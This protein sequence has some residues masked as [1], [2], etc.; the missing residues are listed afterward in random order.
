VDGVTDELIGQLGQISGLRRVISR[1]TAMK[2][3]ET[4][5]TLSEIARELNVDALV[6][7]AVFQVGENVS[8]KLQ[9]FGALPEERSLWTERYERP[10]TDVLVMYGEMARAI[11]QNIQV[12]LTTDETTRFADDR[13]VNPQAYKAYLKG[14]FH[15]YRLNPQDLESALNYFE[16]ALE[17]DP[18][19]ALAYAGI[20]Y[21]WIARQQ[22][23]LLPP[24]VAT[25]E[26]KVAAQRA[27]ELDSTL[28]EVHYA[29]AL[30]KWLCD[31][32]WNGAEAAFKRALA[33]AWMYYS[34]LLGLL[35]RRE[36]AI[37]QA[38]QAL[39]LDPFNSLIAG[40]YGNLLCVLE[41]YD[42][43]IVL[44]RKELRTT[45]NSTTLRESMMR[46]L[47]MRRCFSQQ[48]VR[49]RLSKSW[50]RGMKQAAILKP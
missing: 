1:T 20:S 36:E 29:R 35:Q 3:K 34:H 6:E 23:G 44:A 37:E 30:I 9:L 16:S 32:D 40:L 48:W 27:F 46:P 38:Q 13:Q 26:L 43:A 45:P 50:N 7:G 42:E 18:D 47:N 31:W 8:I 2:Y 17:K 11:A 39:E 21:V 10:V 49:L 28:A 5:K 19:Y 33:D 15:W 14:M 12:K 25:P 24:N 41:R 4:D 22:L